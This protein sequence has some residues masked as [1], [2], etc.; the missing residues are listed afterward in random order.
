[1]VECDKVNATLSVL[2]QNKLRSA[3]KIKIRQEEF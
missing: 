3:A 1:M 2:Q